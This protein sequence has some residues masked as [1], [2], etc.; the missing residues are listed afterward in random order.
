M[1]VTRRL[2]R[3][4]ISA[5]NNFSHLLSAL[6]RQRHLDEGVAPRRCRFYSGRYRRLVIAHHRPDIGTEHD[7]REFPPREVLL[8]PDVLIGRHDHVEPRRFRRVEEL[9]VFKL[10]VP[11]HLDES[12]HFMFGQE[13]PHTDRNG[14]YQRRCA[15]R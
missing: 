11:L 4:D 12:A 10:R 14:S 1:H 8:I 3:I 5:R 13:A 15:M 7:E 9:A 2:I 6:W